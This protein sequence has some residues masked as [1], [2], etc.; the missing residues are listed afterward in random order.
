MWVD[1]VGR[2]MTAAAKPEPIKLHV[3]L[4]EILIDA[5]AFPSCLFVCVCVFVWLSNRQ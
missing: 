1:V 3:I 5:K 4:Y 2:K